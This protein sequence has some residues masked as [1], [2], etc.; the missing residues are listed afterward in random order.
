MVQRG[1]VRV[2][3]E[4]REILLFSF[5]HH[6]IKFIMLCTVTALSRVAGEVNTRSAH[7][8]KGRPEKLGCAAFLGE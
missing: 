2:A 4:L 5:E 7:G 3:P 1:Q 8:V 6:Q